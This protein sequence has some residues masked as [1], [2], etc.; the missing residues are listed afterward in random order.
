MVSRIEAA[1]PVRDELA[2]VRHAR[3][4]NRRL[5][6][7]EVLG[8]LGVGRDDQLVA[9]VLDRV[10][11]AVRARLDD[12]RRLER[13]VGVDE[14]DLARLMVV[15]VD[16]DE[17]RRLRR[18]DGDVEADV[19]LLV[20]EDVVLDR[21]AD[22]VAVDQQRAVVLVEAHIEQRLAV[23]GPHDAAARVGDAVGQI[24]RRSPGRACG[25]CRARS[26]CRRWRRR[27][28]GGRGCAGSRRGPSRACPRPRRCRRAGRLRRSPERGAAADERILTAGDEARVVGERPVG[29]RHGAVV[30][31]EAAVHLA[32]QLVLQGARLREL[33]LAVGVLGVEIGADLRVE[34]GR[35]AHHV[36][37]VVG[38]QP[39]IV[40]DELD[41]VPGGD[42][43]TARGA[44]R[45]DEGVTMGGT[46]HRFLHGETATN[47]GSR[48]DA[49]ERWV[50][51]MGLTRAKMVVLGAVDQ[52]DS[53]KPCQLWEERPG[54]NLSARESFL[55]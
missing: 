17:L 7:A 8:A 18:G 38:L 4:R 23:V 54:H 50:T 26:P 15:R 42:V 53:W 24:D 16:E 27:A 48:A 40:V 49:A 25:W 22:D 37:P 47:M 19:L 51:S 1:G 6:D 35:L 12:A 21:R 14:V 30:L 28:G 20:D 44:R 29:R 11:V 31:L 33:G 46:V 55:K 3:C 5:A 13:R 52:M 10:L 9:V 36:L 43:G 2:P 41:A 34:H 32:E 45:L 39:G